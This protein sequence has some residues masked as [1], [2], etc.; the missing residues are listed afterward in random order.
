VQFI[1]NA[2][3]EEDDHTNDFTLKRS[4]IYYCYFVSAMLLACNDDADERQG[5]CPYLPYLKFEHS[6]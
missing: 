6:Y 5:F 2:R 3:D 4:V 1:S